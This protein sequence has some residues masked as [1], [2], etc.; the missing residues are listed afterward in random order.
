MTGQARG[1]MKSLPAWTYWSQCENILRM[2]AR[3]ANEI[4]IKGNGLLTIS[5]RNGTF[6]TVNEIPVFHAFQ[7]CPMRYACLLSNA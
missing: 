3:K 7:F 5:Y 1:R 4:R 6:V 2:L